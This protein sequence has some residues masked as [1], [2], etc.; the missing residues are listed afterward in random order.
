VAFA[1]R[2]ESL[3]Q[4]ASESA[5]RFA[6]MRSQSAAWSRLH[7]AVGADPQ[8]AQFAVHSSA[9]AAPVKAAKKKPAAKK[10]VAKPAKKAVAKK[11]AAKKAAA[12]K[13]VKKAA[14]KKGRR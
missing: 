14:K 2:V 12:K 5:K 8:G 3:I 13:S 9:A 10:P 7:V 4:T 11:K 6:R 1:T